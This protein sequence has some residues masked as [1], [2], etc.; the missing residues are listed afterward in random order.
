MKI[1]ILTAG[2]R[3]DTQPYVALGL[4]LQKAGHSVRI[5]T[6][7][8][9]KTLVE[10]SGLEFFPVR[11]DVMQVSRS[12]LGREAMSPDNPLKVMRS[13]KQL[14]KLVGDFRKARMD[15]ARS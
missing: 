1:T 6:F 7:G 9:F 14:K 4:A 2:S 5:A 8:N 12:E 11:G 10:C 3:G 15:A 13:F